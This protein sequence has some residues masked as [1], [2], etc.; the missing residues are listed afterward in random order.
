M[1]NAPGK[2]TLSSRRIFVGKTVSLDVDQVRLPDGS[3]GQLEIVRH[4]GAAAVVPFVSNPAEEDPQLLLLR[5]YRY[6]ADGYLYEIPA[7]K[8]DAG[9]SPEACAIRELRE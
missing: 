1:M 2:S 9:E 7:G 6:A 4:P 5:Q 8:V 3:T